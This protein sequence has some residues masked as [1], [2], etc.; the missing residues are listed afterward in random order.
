MNVAVPQYTG[1][2]T[3]LKASIVHGAASMMLT[4]VISAT[5]ENPSRLEYGIGASKCNHFIHVNVMSSFSQSNPQQAVP[6]FG[7]ELTKWLYISKA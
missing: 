5:Y 7:L 6:K 3:D 2:R 1:K 4:H